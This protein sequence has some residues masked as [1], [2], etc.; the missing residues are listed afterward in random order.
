[1]LAGSNGKELLAVTDLRGREKST[2]LDSFAVVRCAPGVD[3]PRRLPKTWRQPGSRALP[4]SIRP[5]LKRRFYHLF[6]SESDQTDPFKHAESVN[7]ILER[8]AIA[9]DE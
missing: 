5:L 8:A 2:Q 6:S 7:G 4:D 9:T 1:M 3:K